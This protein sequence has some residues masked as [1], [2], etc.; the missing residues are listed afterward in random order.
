MKELRQEH[1]V[2]MAEVR[3]ARPWPERACSGDDQQQGVWENDLFMK[4]KQI[5]DDAMVEA[6]NC[7]SETD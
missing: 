7:A 2:D 1:L 3:M 4:F 5:D 6:F